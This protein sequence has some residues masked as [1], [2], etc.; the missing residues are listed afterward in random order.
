VSGF[1]MAS[2]GT[3]QDGIFISVFIFCRY[4]RDS[5]HDIAQAGIGC[6]TGGVL[7]IF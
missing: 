4:I 5:L 7:S 2:N 3:R 6:N 1:F